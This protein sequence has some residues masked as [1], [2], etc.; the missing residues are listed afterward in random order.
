MTTSSSN[1]GNVLVY[2]ASQVNQ[3][4][5][6][7][8]AGDIAAS[9][10]ATVIPKA[11]VTVEA[12]P[13]NIEYGTNPPT[14][15]IQQTQGVSIPPA[16]TAIGLNANNGP[17][18]FSPLVTSGIGINAG[19]A[20][21][22]TATTSLG[23]GAIE[24]SGYG[25]TS[26]AQTTINATSATTI[27]TPQANVLDQYASYTYNLGWYLLTAEQ[28]RNLQSGGSPNP[29]TWYLIARSGGAPATNTSGQNI[30]PGNNGQPS[31]PAGT[32][33]TQSINTSVTGRAPGFS[34]DYYM[35]NLN[36]TQ[37][38]SQGGTGGPYQTSAMDFMVTEPNGITLYNNLYTAVTSIYPNA[39]TDGDKTNP[40]SWQNAMYCM[41]IKFYGYDEHGNLITNPG[42]SGSL[43][44]AN[45]SDPKAI[46]VKYIPFQ[47]TAIKA[48]IANKQIEY[49][50]ECASL[51][52]IAPMSSARG[53]IPFPIEVSGVTVSDVLSGSSG[54]GN[55]VATG[56]DGRQSTPQ[57]TPATASQVTGTTSAQTVTYLNSVA[58]G[59][60]SPLGE[61]VGT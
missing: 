29:N 18:G 52:T 21:A 59:Y 1:V 57:N 4:L 51:G 43:G 53:T 14:V 9:T 26:T 31:E 35:D 42:R 46:L 61:S 54:S 32:A 60:N 58:S 34:L 15:S 33:A 24:D 37:V 10:G 50:I 3:I 49:H 13:S 38:V 30:S 40:A 6:V 55:T 5:P 17:I 19:T 36:I 48:T 41:V 45:N 23:V 28:V 16:G 11:T 39:G 8:S 22:T 7:A 25:N 2:S 27:I 56:N 20:Q 12:A 44:S 47:I